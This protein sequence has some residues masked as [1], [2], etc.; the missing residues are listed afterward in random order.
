MPSTASFLVE[1]NG[2]ALPDDVAALLMAGYV[3]CSLRLPDAFMLRNHYAD[4]KMP[5]VI[6][7][8]ERTC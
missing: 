1:L 8:G 4:L 2:S 3:D 5:V 6:I 7:A